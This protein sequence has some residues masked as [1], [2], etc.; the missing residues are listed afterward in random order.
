[1]AEALRPEGHP[2]VIIDLN[3]KTVLEARS[4]GVSAYVGDATS[5]EILELAVTPQARQ[6]VI[7]LPDQ[8]AAIQTLRQVRAL[9]PKVR[10]ICRARYHVFVEELESAGAHAVVDEEASVGKRL[11]MEVLKG[12]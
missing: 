11:G 4:A 9:N 2:L 5:P 6:V 1:M 7:T 8:R 3:A 12:V 10:V